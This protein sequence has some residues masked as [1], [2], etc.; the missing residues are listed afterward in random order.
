MYEDV[1]VEWRR[2]MRSDGEKCGYGG[3][4]YA[5]VCSNEREILDLGKADRCTV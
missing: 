3:C 1:A 5:Y 2:I 4:L